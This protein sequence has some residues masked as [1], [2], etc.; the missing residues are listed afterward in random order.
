V[1]CIGVPVILNYLNI[2][3]P[4]NPNNVSSWKFQLTDPSGILLTIPNIGTFNT[5]AQLHAAVMSHIRVFDEVTKGGYTKL[6]R[7]EADKWKETLD[8]YMGRVIDH[9]LCVTNRAVDC[10]NEGLGDQIHEVMG[11]VDGY[12]KKTPEVVRKKVE[13]AIQRI[14]PSRSKSFG[15]CSACGGSRVFHPYENPL[16][17]AGTVNRWTKGKKK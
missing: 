8:Q 2:V 3:R 11:K 1:V 13:A 16:G 17:R 4:K 7:E 15:G 5:K 6:I 14:T 9:Q 10:W 12:V